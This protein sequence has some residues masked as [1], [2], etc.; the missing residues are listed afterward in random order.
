MAILALLLIGLWC[1]LT[2]YFWVAVALM[3]GSISS[4]FDREWMAAYYTG[5]LIQLT[6]LAWAAILPFVSLMRYASSLGDLKDDSQ[7]GLERALQLNRTFWK[8]SSY[9]AW[10]VAWLLVYLL[11]VATLGTVLHW[12]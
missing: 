4:K 6:F 8:Q 9:L 11:G 2:T 12:Q 3:K 7:V 1:L 10:G 5:F